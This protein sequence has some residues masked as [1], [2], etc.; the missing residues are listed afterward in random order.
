MGET[1]GKGGDHGDS[2]DDVQ[3]PIKQEVIRRL[4]EE[5]L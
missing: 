2:T 4:G 3:A 1:D 5:E